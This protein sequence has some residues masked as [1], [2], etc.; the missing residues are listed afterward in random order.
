MLTVEIV[1]R[2]KKGMLEQQLYDRSCSISF[3]FTEEQ[4]NIAKHLILL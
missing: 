3:R 2:K 1:S 4:R